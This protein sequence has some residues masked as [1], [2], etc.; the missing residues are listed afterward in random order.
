VL[1]AWQQAVKTAEWTAVRRAA[2]MEVSKAASMADP[3]VASKVATW[4]SLLAVSKAVHLVCL[5]VDLLVVS[6]VG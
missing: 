5:M 4:A 6:K 2:L 3:M 1:K